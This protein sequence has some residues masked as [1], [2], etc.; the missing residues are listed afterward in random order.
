MKKAMKKA[1][2]ILA[3]PF[4]L[5]GCGINT[6]PDSEGNEI[7]DPVE[8]V[9]DTTLSSSETSP[10]ETTASPPQ[11]EAIKKEDM[12]LNDISLLDLMNT[13]LKFTDKYLDEYWETKLRCL[14]CFPV[15][16]RSSDEISLTE[17]LW[18]RDSTRKL[19]VSDDE[20]E[21]FVSAVS[22]KSYMPLNSAEKALQFIGD[23]YIDLR[24]QDIRQV[25][26]E[27][28]AT[29]SSAWCSYAIVDKFTP[30]AFVCRGDDGLI[31]FIIDPAYMIGVPLIG[32]NPE[33]YTFDINGTEV[34]MDSFI[35][36]GNSAESFSDVFEGRGNEFFYARLELD[37]IWVEYD[38]ETGYRC[39]ASLNSIE[40]ITD[41]VESVLNAPLKDMFTDSED[42][43]AEMTEAYNVI[44]ENYDTLCKDS[45]RG[46]VLLD[47]DFDGKAELLVSDVGV[48]DNGG[49]EPDIDV[50]VSIYR[51]ENNAL[52]YIAAFPCDYKVV[53]EIQMSL[54]LKELPDG[55][56]GWFTTNNGGDGYVYRL[57]GDKWIPTEIFT[58]KSVE[59]TAD[60]Y[61]YYFMG[62]EII[63]NLIHE[64]E[65]DPEEAYYVETHYEWNG[66]YSYFGEMWELYGKI[67]EDYCADI[68]ETYILYS[69]WLTENIAERFEV[70]PREASYNIAYM[71]DS[72]YLGDYNLA[73]RT[74]NYRFLGDYAKPVI[75]L[76]PLKETEVSV[77]VSFAEEGELTCTYP[78]YG[79]GWNVTA[80]P[81]GTLYDKDGN[82]YY[83]LYWEGKGT[84]LLNDGGGWCVKGEDT[85]VFL[86]EKLL[87]IGLTPREANEF[88]IYWLP[89]MQNNAYNII[90]FHTEDY[91]LSVPLE[92]SP[93]PD[94]QIRVFMTFEPSEEEVEIPPQDLPHYERNGFT[95]VEWGGS[96]AK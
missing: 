77:K 2:V 15:S 49:W 5:S 41:D 55:T 61:V 39:E 75:Y 74:F 24:I 12:S 59:G 88:I 40:P 18:V 82:E 57:I 95:L 72:F 9:S 29:A 96:K 62:E 36:V 37:H 44:M 70:T 11:T 8:T 94:T 38:F 25:D 93:A 10:S 43:P 19:A 54:G 13:N 64:E 16:Y 71:V 67:R 23:D 80:L 22:G 63:P 35:C 91:A 1:A 42:K 46:I 34:M 76:Y 86:R 56:K 14:G 6:V 20:K 53:Y 51:I 78:D 85:A 27:L 89:E 4:L 7:T 47:L 65:M 28:I 90:T 50:R 79:D 58:R 81:D 33:H 45:T 68:E 92:V 84:A 21:Y 30:N 3:F 17:Q 83:C 60:E 69:D 26:S 48:T 52:K 87:E 66:S 73:S 32:K 31:R